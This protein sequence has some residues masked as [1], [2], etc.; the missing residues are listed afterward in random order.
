MLT[1]AIIHINNHVF[2]TLEKP[3]TTSEYEAELQNLWRNLIS[4]PE[5][6]R[7]S[8]QLHRPPHQPAR[9]TAFPKPPCLSYCV[10]YTTITSYASFLHA[11]RYYQ[12]RNSA[13]FSANSVTQRPSYGRAA[14]DLGHLSTFLVFEEPQLLNGPGLLC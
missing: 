10:P 12:D 14:H 2:L 5:N 1:S 7:I 8:S 6:V 11:S 4:F 9:G 13:K 3:G